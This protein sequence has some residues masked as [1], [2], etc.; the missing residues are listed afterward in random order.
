MNT[1]LFIGLLLTYI[2]IGDPLNSINCSFAL[3]A[4]VTARILNW[5]KQRLEIR[6][7]WIRNI[8]LFTGAIMVL[9]SLHKAVPANFITLSWALSAVVFFILSILI[10]NMKY[11]WLAIITMVLTVFYL[12]LVDLSNI[13]L[14]YRIVALMFIS[15]IS[16]AISMFYS[17]R[18]RSKKE[19]QS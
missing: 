4:L 10:K 19:E 12:F 7:E 6:T 14:G 17:R 2:I 15:M 9:F 18:Q 5:K 1:I 13:S 11:R 3:V 8:F 16:L